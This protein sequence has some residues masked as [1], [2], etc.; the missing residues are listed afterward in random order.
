M[1]VLFLDI[2]GVLLP[3]RAYNLPNQTSPIV[4]V[5]DPCAVVMLNNACERQDRRIVIHSS[6]IHTRVWKI[7]E[8]GKGDVHDYLISQ[9]VN[10]DL[11]HDDKYC[12]RELY[13]RYDRIAEWLARN[14]EVTDYVILD[15]EPEPKNENPRFEDH[16]VLT[17]FD[18]GITM[19][20]YR[21]I[22][23]G[24]FPRKN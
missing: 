14:P 4:K 23:H 2:D 8:D 24:S 6:W 12:N 11:F 22:R 13:Q 21:K 15:D 17:D 19:E 9:G 5:F 1:R 16:L 18:E 10:A 20:V 3:G 7:G